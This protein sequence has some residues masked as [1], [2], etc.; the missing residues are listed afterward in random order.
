MDSS[1]QQFQAWLFQV[2]PVDV[3]S[4]LPSTGICWKLLRPYQ[5]LWCPK[6]ISEGHLICFRQTQTHPLKA[7]VV[8]FK[9]TW[10]WG[11]E[12]GGYNSYLS[13]LICLQTAES[14][15]FSIQKPP[16]IKM[17]AELIKYLSTDNCWSVWISEAWIKGIEGQEREDHISNCSVK[18]QL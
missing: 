1:W 17:S 7:K 13:S 2:W 10:G 6:L 11:R 16:D 5:A 18:T 8:F 3:E 14:F 9:E 12:G 4:L 15:K